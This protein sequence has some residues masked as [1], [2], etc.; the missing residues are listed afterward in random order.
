MSRTKTTYGACRLSVVPIRKEA[1]H[2]SEL[3]T[4]LLFG[5][6]YTILE[7][8]SEWV[9]II[10]KYDG[11]EGWLAANQVH[12]IEEKEFERPMD[13]YCTDLMR[14]NASYALYVFMGSPLEGAAPSTADK[15][16][17]T[18]VL[19]AAEKYKNAP[20]LWGGRS[21]FGVDCSGL[22]QVLFKIVGQQVPRDAYQ[23]AE[24][25]QMVNWG[26][27]Q[28]GDVAFFVNKK[29][30]ITHVGVI[31]DYDRIIHA[32]GWVREDLLTK[33]G[34]FHEQKKTHKLSHIQRWG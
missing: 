22:T 32:S 20:Y 2:R 17:I 11:Y 26:R 3:V 9:R 19:A 5:E 8:R 15:S 1:S 31:K 34:I 25:G 6:R 23:Q 30:K 16:K 21:P 24:I 28:R 4:Q 13:G 27:H 14:W 29:G 7:E 18:K 12:Y 33:E 10:G